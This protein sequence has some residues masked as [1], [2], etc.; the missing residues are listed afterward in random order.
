MSGDLI[1][2]LFQCCRFTGKLF[3]DGSIGLF[4]YLFDYI[5]LSEFCATNGD[6]SVVVNQRFLLRPSFSVVYSLT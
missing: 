6:F 4:D 2:P 3:L 5:Y 1:E